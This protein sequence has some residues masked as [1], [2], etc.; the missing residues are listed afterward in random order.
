MISSKK[1]ENLIITE[2]SYKL[3]S[4]VDINEVE[5]LYKKVYEVKDQIE[6]LSSQ[7]EEFDIAIFKDINVCI[8]LDELGS[9]LGEYLND[10]E[11]YEQH[12]DEEDEEDD[13]FGDF[14]QVGELKSL[15]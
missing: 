15:L 3:L 7:L 1:N 9:Y 8:G 12:F 10:R 13:T 6:N 4:N 11:S 5:V 2:V 14:N